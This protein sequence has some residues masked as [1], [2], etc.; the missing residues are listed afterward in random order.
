MKEA[1]L[2]PLEILQSGTMNPA[3]FFGMEDK[4]GIIEAGM[5]ADLLLL[6][7]NPLED[8]S[9][10]K[11]LSGVM[12]RGRW[13]DRTAIDEKLAEIARNAGSR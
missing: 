4:F 5:A 7:A 6:D 3:R 8:L 13:L 1:G 12:V 11:A 9:A 10:L 2:S